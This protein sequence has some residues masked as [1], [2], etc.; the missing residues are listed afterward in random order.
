MTA[1]GWAA[2]DSSPAVAPHERREFLVHDADQRLPRVQAAHDVLAHRAFLDARDE[3]THH[4]Q[5]D[6][7][8]EQSHADFTQHVLRI[9]LGQAGFPAHGLDRPRQTLS[10]IIEHDKCFA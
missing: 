9:G 2:S 1:G 10:Q 8:L 4:R 3:I 6:V 7:G 5:G